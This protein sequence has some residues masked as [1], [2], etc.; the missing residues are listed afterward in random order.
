MKLNKK[1]LLHDG[2]G[3]IILGLMW[4]LGSLACLCPFCIFGTISLFLNGI[5][6]KLGIRLIAQRKNRVFP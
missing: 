3:S 5:K 1:E 6:E 4:G 2:N